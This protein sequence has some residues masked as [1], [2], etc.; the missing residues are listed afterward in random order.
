[1]DFANDHRA[2]VKRYAFDRPGKV[3]HDRLSGGR[4]KS[5]NK[6]LKLAAFSKTIRLRRERHWICSSTTTMLERPA[7]PLKTAGMNNHV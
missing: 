3:V 5:Q 4:M 2:A 6:Y 1:M 7:L